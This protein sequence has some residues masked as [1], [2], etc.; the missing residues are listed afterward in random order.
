MN[1]A[2]PG[3][4][5]QVTFAV[6]GMTCAACQAFVE[7][8]LGRQPGVKSAAVNLLTH[9]A[10]VVFDAGAVSPRALVETVNGTGY[11]AELPV[12]ARGAALEQAEEDRRELAGYQA[13]KRRALVSLAAALAAMAA[14]MPLMAH[15]QADPLLHRVA[16]WLDAPFRAALPWLY[17]VP[18]AA[19]RWFLLLLAAAVMAWAGRRFFV[20]AWAALRHRTA[21]MNSLIALGTGAAFLYSAA[22][23]A[24]PGWF[25]SRGVAPEVYFETVVFILALVLSGNALE[26]R[27][28]RKMSAALQ[29]LAALRPPSARIERGPS[30]LDIPLDEL[31]LGDIAVVRPG[32][33]IPADGVVAGGES[34]VDESMLTGEPLPVEKSPG[35]Q[36][37]GGTL[38]LHGR[39][40]VRVTALGAESVLER[41]LRLLREA[42]AGKAR[43]QRLADRVSAIFVPA[44][45]AVSLLTLGVWLGWSGEPAVRGFTAA[46]AVLVIACPCA[47]GLAVPAAVLAATGR[48]ARM[49]VLFRDGEAIERLASANVVVFDKTGTLT[50]GRHEAAAIEP[51]PGFTEDSMLT[52]LAALESASE[53][54]LARAIVRAAEARGL[55]LP[56]VEE[57]RALPGLGAEG[58][59]G[60]VRLLA[61]R[62][63]L[64]A[65]RGIALPP[66][67]GHA[68]L[69]RTVVFFAV[70][71]RYAGLLALADQPRKEAREVVRTLRRAGLRVLML[72]GDNET[73]ARAVARETGIE[74]VAA[75]VLPEG[76]LETI[77][78]LQAQG[79]QVA[80]VGD[81]INDAPALAAAGAGI[82][83]FSGADV[84]AHVSGAA[85]MRDDLWGVARAR[86]LAR[87]TVR[88]MRQNL[89]WALI[90]N[91]IGIPVAAGVLYPAFGLLLSPVLAG[92]A[93]AFSSVSVL[94]NSLRL[95]GTG[96]GAKKELF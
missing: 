69:G 32:E 62:R 56:P 50:T 13:L 18:A 30:E 15:S 55:S 83:M 28:R 23:T 22:V 5:A 40:R 76:K 81:G 85:L 59:S 41:I 61:G 65:E 20:K 46:V 7:K 19:L 14:S 17:E 1:P 9:S 51:A 95:A 86:G 2:G 26:A 66:A 11:Q 3:A 24:A 29:S 78:A 96:A 90:Y 38:N 74:E 49:G 25:E 64:M 94:A 36:V 89:F 93:M 68:A 52:L 71:G 12:A 45:L 54:P 6:R 63:E 57:F 21:D 58:S 48:A 53:H 75:G 27:A 82:A 67:Q 73:T 16:M 60:G 39:L 70:D 44:V 33:R 42:Q 77:R 91:L 35:A 31:Q 43:L 37:T 84:A 80:M 79:L 8:T 10:T 34:S 92:A 47:M 88:T 4:E 72:T 87:A